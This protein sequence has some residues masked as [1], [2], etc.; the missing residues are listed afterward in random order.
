MY[1]P[2]NGNGFRTGS[3]QN[4]MGLVFNCWSYRLALVHMAGVIVFGKWFDEHLQH[5]EQFPA[6][7]GCEEKSLKVFPGLFFLRGRSRGRSSKSGGSQD[8]QLPNQ[9]PRNTSIFCFFLRAIGSL[10][11]VSEDLHPLLHV[12][13][14]EQVSRG[15]QMRKCHRR[16]EKQ[17]LTAPIFG[18]PNNMITHWP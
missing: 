2:T 16:F 5:L 11:R 8:N 13:T 1:T 10:F 9:F 7:S 3:I 12:L 6:F 15:Q 17:L 18:Y 14:K 4:P